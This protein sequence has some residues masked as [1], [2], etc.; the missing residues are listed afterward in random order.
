MCKKPY[1]LHFYKS[2]KAIEENDWPCG[3]VPPG[4]IFMCAGIVR[5]QKSLNEIEQVWFYVLHEE[6]IGMTYC[7]MPFHEFLFRVLEE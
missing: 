3:V 5:R 1:N 4:S 6:L 7:Q 2:I